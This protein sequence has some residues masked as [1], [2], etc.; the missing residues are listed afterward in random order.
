MKFAARIEELGF[1]VIP[2][3]LVDDHCYHL[4]TCL[5][6]LN[7]DA[8]LIYPGAYSADAMNQLR[9]GWKR[10]HELS[11]EEAVQFIGNGI[12]ANGRYITARMTDNL[13]RILDAEGLTP[14]LV[15]TSEFEKSGGSVF[16]MKCAIE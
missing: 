8:A 16:C 5:C 12:V 6:P 1:P 4:D 7:S 10:L 14:V 3:Q 13:K 2:L 11:R 15:D 9:S